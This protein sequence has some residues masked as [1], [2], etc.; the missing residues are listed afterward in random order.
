MAM[1]KRNDFNKAVQA[2]MAKAKKTDIRAKLEWL[3][4][5]NTNSERGMV[6][7]QCEINRLYS[8]DNWRCECGASKTVHVKAHDG[9]AFKYIV[10]KRHQTGGY[11]PSIHRERQRGNVAK[12]SGNQLIDEINC[13]QEFADTEYAD[14][15]CP[16]L[17]Y[18]TSKSDK[19]AATSETMQRNVVIIAQRAVYVGDASDACRKAERLN[20]ENRYHGEDSSVRYEKLRQLSKRQG[21]RDAMHNPGNSGV[22]FD[23]SKG[24]YKAVF[25]DYAL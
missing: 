24:C 8:R 4:A 7:D 15:L 14:L 1:A 3:I 22:V 2:A 19:V 10:I 11:I 12:L 13:W 6:Y 21:W 23:Y 18:F 5:C 16:I 20:R 9:E 25:I 17:K